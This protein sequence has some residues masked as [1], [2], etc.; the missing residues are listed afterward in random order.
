MGIG[1]TAEGAADGA[2]KDDEDDDGNLYDGGIMI[3]APF[4]DDLFGDY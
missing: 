2:A 3:E 1:G 4:D